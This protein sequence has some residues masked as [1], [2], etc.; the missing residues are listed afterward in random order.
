[1]I[2]SAGSGLTVLPVAPASPPFWPASSSSRERPGP[3]EAEEVG[4]G[5]AAVG[6]SAPPGAD[7]AAEKL[8]GTP[9]PL[10]G[11]NGTQPMPSKI[12][13]GHACSCPLETE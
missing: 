2:V 11:S 6:S 4:A 12:T 10:V 3:A 5:V 9:R 8:V 1:M 13:S 7:P